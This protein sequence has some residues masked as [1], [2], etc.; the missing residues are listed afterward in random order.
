MTTFSEFVIRDDAHYRCVECKKTLQA[1]EIKLIDAINNF[2]GTIIAV[3]DSA[4]IYVDKED[5]IVRGSHTA[6]KKDGDKLL[7]CPHCNYVHFFGFEGA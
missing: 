7:A 2:G 6:C 5:R 1:G 4:F 3:M